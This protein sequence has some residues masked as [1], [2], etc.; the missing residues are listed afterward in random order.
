MNKEQLFWDFYNA[1]TEGEVKRILAR[2]GL[3]QSQANWRPY[4]QNESNFSV[5]ENQQASP[6]PALIEKITNG[7]DAILMR[8]CIEQGL[9]PKVRG[10]ATF[11]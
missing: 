9:D 7:I 3:I 2:Y 5:V 4:G 10:S 8:M 1:P 11:N 6:I